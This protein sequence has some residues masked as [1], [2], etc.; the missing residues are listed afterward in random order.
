MHLHKQVWLA[1]IS[2]GAL[3]T[4]M[5]LVAFVHT[6][7]SN[8]LSMMA[9]APTSQA[10]ASTM[11]ETSTFVGHAWDTAVVS[12]LLP[13]AVM[14]SLIPFDSK[15]SFDALVAASVDAHGWQG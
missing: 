10:R 1:L 5:F 11:V 3:R 6:P 15:K 7:W 8:K 4:G 9:F 14:V 13:G 2:S 12:G